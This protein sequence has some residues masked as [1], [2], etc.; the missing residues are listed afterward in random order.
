VFVESKLIIESP[1][2]ETSIIVSESHP[3]SDSAK[4]FVGIRNVAI[5]EKNI[6][7]LI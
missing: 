3:P 1:T 5:T 2:I 6:K 7:T 4:M